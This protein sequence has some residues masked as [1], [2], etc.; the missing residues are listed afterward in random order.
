MKY[1]NYTFIL[2]FFLFSQ[3]AMNTAQQEKKQVN[4][5]WLF[6]EDIDP[7]MPV[8]GD[9][10]IQ[11]PNIDFLAQNG[12][13]FTNCFSMSPVCSPARSG[14]F[15]GAMPTT[16]GTH[17]HRAGRMVNKPL[18]DHVKVLPELFKAK[19]YH[20]FSEGKD[21]FNWS[22]DWNDYWSG[23]YT[24]KKHFGKTGTGSWNDREEGQPFFG[25]IELYGG[26][27]KNKPKHLVDPKDVKVMPYYPDIPSIRK[28]IADHY[29]QIKVTDNEI[30]ELIK[31]LKKD[32]LY[33]NTIIIFF[34]DN[35]YNLLRDKQFLYDAGLHMPM[36]ISSPGNPDLLK[37]SG[38][39]EDLMSLL[40][41]TATTL[42]LADIEVPEYMES[43][44]VF[45][46]NYHR[47]FVI[48]ARDRCDFTID[49]IRSVRTKKFK[50]IKN[51]MTDR[52]LMQLQYR[53]HKKRTIA[54]MEA[55]KN[56]VEFSSD[57]LSDIRPAEELYD[58][59]KD[60]YELHNLASNPDYQ[61]E[62]IQHRKTLE[63]WIEETDDKGQYPESQEQLKAVFERYGE[64]CINP[65]FDFLKA[66]K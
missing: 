13:T 30:G 38:V 1:I 47:D 34:S 43:Q 4:I 16:I 2:F 22:Y 51:F 15:T 9:S 42:H 64:R 65:E 12:V 23:S 48:G 63:L 18:P 35:G 29:N 57:W 24:E 28:Q 62:L 52:P 55:Y 44:N 33:E 46:K 39:R 20:T 6:G 5:L 8:Y 41:L 37:Q 36:I 58:L 11:T 14:I 25:V 21:D 45:D 27:N 54:V 60:P 10:T 50:Y 26:K 17:N 56:G 7:W 31:Q 32:S 40:D 49:R 53:S 19:G 61:A 66:T 3:C 59:E